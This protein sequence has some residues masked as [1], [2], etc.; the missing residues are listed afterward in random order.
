MNRHTQ[1]GRALEALAKTLVMYAVSM[2]VTE[3]VGAVVGGSPVL[4]PAYI[5]GAIVA[6]VI[7]FPNFYRS[8][9]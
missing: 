3:L 8:T 9:K 6:L 4:A 1:I 2:L 5:V 7:G